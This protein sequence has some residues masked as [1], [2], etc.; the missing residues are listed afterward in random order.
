MLG[1]RDETAEHDR[2][3]A[4]GDEG[5]QHLDESVELRVASVRQPFREMNEV[6]ER[7]MLPL[8]ARG[9]LDVDRVRLVGVVVEDLLFEP[10]GIGG[11]PVPQ[12]ARRRRR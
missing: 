11:E 4:L 2:V 10:V 6:A 8:D 7:S 12:R 5:L 1:G 3:R 9:R